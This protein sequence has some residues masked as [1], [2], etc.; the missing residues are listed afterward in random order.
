MASCAGWCSA[1]IDLEYPRVAYVPLEF[2]VHFSLN[3]YSYLHCFPYFT[4]R[5]KPSAN[6]REATRSTTPDPNK[7]NSSTHVP[8]TVFIS[9]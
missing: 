7:Q 5:L 2:P 8:P 9:S 4:L 3:A 1:G 6:I